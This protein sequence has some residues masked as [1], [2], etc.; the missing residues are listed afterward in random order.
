MFKYL[1]QI[2]SESLV[3]GLAGVISRFLSVF[4]VPIYTRLFTP[5]DY[6]VMS[7][8]STTMALV[9][10]LVGF[11]LDSAAHRWF[12]DSEAEGHRKATVA[13]WAWCALGSSFVFAGLVYAF[14][15]WLAN[16]LVRRSDA[17][18]YFSL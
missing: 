7:L 17:A 18:L 13:T 12:W 8:V 5:E 3:Y 9:A 6:G 15:G 11:S 4:L 1:K 14:S 10:S 2:V 16:A